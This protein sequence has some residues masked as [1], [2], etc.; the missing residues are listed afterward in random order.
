MKIIK[1]LIIYIAII[2]LLGCV[3]EK[4]LPVVIDGSLNE[5]IQTPAVFRVRVI[6]ETIYEKDKKS[7]DIG[8]KLHDSIVYYLKRNNIYPA[9]RN[10]DSNKYIIIANINEFYHGNIAGQFILSGMTD[11]FNPRIKFSVSICEDNEN[12]KI[13]KTVAT[14]PN[15]ELN[16]KIYANE[17]SFDAS[18]AGAGYRIVETIY[19][20]FINP[21]AEKIME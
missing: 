7:I 6:G 3:R 16:F 20:N 15:I 5:S 12:D 14:I 9:L 8:Q 11:Q 19:L 10:D 2:S 4:G 17:T 18:I 1:I 13:G 21:D